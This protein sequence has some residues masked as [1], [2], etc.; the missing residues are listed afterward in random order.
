MI[1]RIGIFTISLLVSILLHYF[2]IYRLLNIIF[3]E[4]YA[5]LFVGILAYIFYFLTLIILKEVKKIEIDLSFILYLIVIFIAI[6][7]KGFSISDVILN[8]LSFLNTKE[9]TITQS[10]LNILLFVPLGVY[11]KY[12]KIPIFGLA[13]CF[14]LIECFQYLFGV[15]TFD[16]GDITLYFI[17]LM[18][19]ILSYKI[20]KEK[21]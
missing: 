9:V 2:I 10:V 3:L 12:Y 21:M 5:V 11:Q 13:L 15:G 20:Y 14:V 7:L 1:K 4:R 16:L 19:G 6:F 17:G 8:P 18:I